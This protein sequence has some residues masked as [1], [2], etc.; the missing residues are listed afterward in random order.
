MNR[1]YKLSKLVESYSWRTLIVHFILIGAK[2][3]HVINLSH[4]LR[5]YMTSS[6]PSEGHYY[7]IFHSSWGGFIEELFFY[8][9]RYYSVT[10]AFLRVLTGK[11]DFSMTGYKA[12]NLTEIQ[13]PVMAA[14]LSNAPTIHTG[15]AVVSIVQQ[16]IKG[17][18][19]I[20][21]NLLKDF[22]PKPLQQLPS[23]IHEVRVI[24][25]HPLDI[26]P[27]D[28]WLS[29]AERLQMPV[30][31]RDHH[32]EIDMIVLAQHLN[33]PNLTIRKNL[34]NGIMDLHNAGYEL[35]NH[36]HLTH[37][38]AHQIGDEGAV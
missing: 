18:V 2:M 8:T 17:E 4:S 24:P 33:S 30:A 29:M 12:K 6:N 26:S 37:A 38:E 22:S 19:D 15:N 16:V 32:V 5:V 3:V 35:R 10:E 14:I 9:S 1:F 23:A 20:D 36:P 34:H 27:I 21:E 11:R 31:V 25:K 13:R 7:G 28:P